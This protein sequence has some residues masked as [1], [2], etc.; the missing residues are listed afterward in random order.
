LNKHGYRTVEFDSVDWA[1]SIVIFGC[2]NV[3]GIGVGEEDT[4]S[5]QL[6]KITK[7]PVINMGVGGS[8]MEYS[9][10]NSVVLKDHYPTPKAV[11]QIWSSLSRTTYY[12]KKN[13][14]HHGTWGMKPNDYMDLY[15]TDP[16][17][18]LVHGLMYQSI[19]KQLWGNTKYYETSFFD[20]T[21]NKLNM[22]SLTWCDAARD[23]KHP[24]RKTLYK[25][26]AQIAAS[27]KV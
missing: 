8:S 13:V 19:S 18:G 6:S 23:L 17:H 1:N 2:S 7:L 20:D 24:G 27:I 11:V 12:T 21:V 25:L 15:S 9:L 10:Y 4:L 5:S 22:P 16:T 26:A 14:T 3:Y